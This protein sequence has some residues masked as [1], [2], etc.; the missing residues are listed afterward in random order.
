MKDINGR[1]R[2]HQSRKYNNLEQEL[3]LPSVNP[4]FRGPSHR[5]KSSFSPPRNV[6]EPFTV[7]RA[8]HVQRKGSQSQKETKPSAPSQENNK[9]NKNIFSNNQSITEYI[10]TELLKREKEYQRKQIS[11]NSVILGKLFN[12][13]KYLLPQKLTDTNADPMKRFQFNQYA[14]DHTVFNRTL[15]DVR[16]PL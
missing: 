1:E 9:M 16:N 8:A 2:R 5:E 7:S 3:N 14:S 12:A 4:F 10:R 6:N 15:W 11:S 13:E